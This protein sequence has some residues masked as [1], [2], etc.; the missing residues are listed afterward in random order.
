[1]SEC[2]R[3]ALAHLRVQ[4]DVS[5]RPGF[6]LLLRYVAELAV[7]RGRVGAL[8]RQGSRLTAQ[9]LRGAKG[10]HLCR[11]GALCGAELAARRHAC[12]LSWIALGLSSRVPHVSHA[13]KTGARAR[14]RVAKS[15][16]PPASPA[17]VAHA[18]ALGALQTRKT[19]A[20]VCTDRTLRRKALKR[21]RISR[22]LSQLH[23]QQQRS[24]ARTSHAAIKGRYQ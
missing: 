7:G 19:C 18:R 9:C 11:A 4:P 14:D 23:T 3:H 16:L 21:R 17:A 5:L 20:Y 12:K 10:Q 13:S 8:S 1:M 24:H 22:A 6:P 2:R 15:W